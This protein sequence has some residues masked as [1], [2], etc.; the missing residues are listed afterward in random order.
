MM[1]SHSY[2]DWN[3]TAP[4][5]PE[6]REAMLTALDLPGNPS[7]VHGPGRRARGVMDQA[8]A[9]VAALIGVKPAQLVFTSGG[10]E[11]DVLALT[12]T[13]RKAVLLSGIEHDAVRRAAPADAVTLPVGSDGVLDLGALEAL[14]AK[15]HEPAL[16]SV[17]AANNETGVIQ[18]IAE[19]AR[20]AHAHG[21]LFHCDAVQLAGRQPLD[22]T[23]LGIDLLTLSAHKIGGPK[24]V[25]AL[26][27]RE[28]LGL[29]PLIPGGGQESR[30][31]GGTENLPGIA[32]F[33][34]AALAAQAGMAEEGARI[35]AL[36]DG[37]EAAL[38]AALPDLVIFGETAPRIPNTS[39]IGHPGLK[40]ET[41][42]MA[43][44]LAGV[45][46][47]AGAACSSGKVERSAVLDAMGV[48][49]VLAG[50]AIRISLGWTTTPE[51]VERC[52]AAYCAIA[53]RQDKGH[54]KGHAA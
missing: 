39:L 27:L 8:R 28:G 35:T 42:V 30:R 5:R 16:V 52:I 2:L 41:V 53:R 34:A 11:A 14:L 23:G 51:E 43:M 47:S 44:D 33:G 3:A 38:K 36:R 25:G 31:R 50:S 37:M 26:A 32:G 20:I 19:V 9:A 40:A 13:G 46:V 22:M 48:D 45:A 49:P 18:P 4:L 24:G 21:A 7:S 29:T 12:G 1:R 10:T 6:A 17:M 54:G 15:A